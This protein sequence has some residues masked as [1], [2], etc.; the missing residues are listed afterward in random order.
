LPGNVGK[1]PITDEDGWID[2]FVACDSTPSLLFINNRDGTFREEGLI[3]LRSHRSAI[4]IGAARAMEQFAM[5]ERRA[6]RLVELGRSS[7]P[8]EAA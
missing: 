2:I 5:S 7:Y 6:C 3:R 8:L 4:L 1:G